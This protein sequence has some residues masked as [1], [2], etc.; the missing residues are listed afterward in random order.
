M[1]APIVEMVKY[2]AEQMDV[3]KSQIAKGLSD[4]ELQYFLAFCGNK[5]LD[6][7]TKQV[8]AIKRGGSMTIQTGIDGFRS[9]ANRSGG[10]APGTESWDV[11][12]NGAL[13]SATVTV[14][15]LVAGT[16]MEFGATAH[17]AEYA[18]QQGLWSKMPKTMLAKCAE[19]KALR[20]GWPDELGGVY[21][22]EEMDQAATTE[23]SS[24]QSISDSMHANGGAIS[25]PPQQSRNFKKLPPPPDRFE[26]IPPEVCGKVKNLQQYSGKSIGSLEYVAL[27]YLAG[28]MKNASSLVSDEEQRRYLKLLWQD[29]VMELDRRDADA[30]AMAQDGVITEDDGMLP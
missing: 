12:T 9:I 22:P 23:L 20:K 13:V 6:P 7:F 27:Q 15:K 21:S 3:I 16:W 26:V 11:D 19:A 14:K 8:Y 18:Q 25:S 28:Y 5:R 24:G 2:S 29:L 30:D 17:A 10:Y 1:S 4:T